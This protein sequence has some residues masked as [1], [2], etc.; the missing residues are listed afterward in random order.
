MSPVNRARSAFCDIDLKTFLRKHIPAPIWKSMSLAK[1]MVLDFVD[2]LLGRRDPMVPPRRMIFV[3]SGDFLAIG[4]AFLDL[5]RK[6]GN[7]QPQHRVLDVGCGIGRMAIPLTKYL[8]SG[9]SY[10]GFDI[11]PRGIKWCTEKITPHYENFK[12]QLADIRNSEYNATGHQTAAE[13]R[14][15]YLDR[16]FDFVFLTSVFTHMKSEDVENYLA[17]I[18]RV[19]K[20]EGRCF[21]TWFLL[22]A[23]SRKLMRE[24]RSAIDFKFA[25]GNLLTTNPEVPEEAIAYDEAYVTSLYGKAGLTLITPIYFGSWC[26]RENS[27]ASYQDICIAYK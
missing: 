25:F 12:F 19:L 4:E 3:G 14:F 8:T 1:S 17:E 21:I 26:N 10:E 22:N 13:F 24:G 5:F 18:E 7:L 2:S 15:P 20:P 11:V 9:G 6:L 27:F 23:E 16:E